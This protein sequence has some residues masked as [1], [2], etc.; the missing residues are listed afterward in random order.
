MI[1][2]VII[3]NAGII[4]ADALVAFEHLGI[5]PASGTKLA[6]HLAVASIRHT[7]TIKRARL[8]HGGGPLQ[9][10]EQ[11]DNDGPQS[12]PDHGPCG[13]QTH[14]PM[15]A[16][17]ADADALA[18]GHP[19]RDL[20]GEA[21]PPCPHNAVLPVALSDAA[22]ASIFVTHRLNRCQSLMSGKQL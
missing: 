2:P 9:N 7:A 19:P 12:D 22:C 3:G 18:G 21:P 1:H 20:S 6:K 14:Q 16:D 15:A 10:A 11:A 5:N 13:A 17:T 8:S 4:T